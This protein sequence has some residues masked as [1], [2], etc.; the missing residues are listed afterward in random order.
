MY[1]PKILRFLFKYQ[2][3]LFFTF[4]YKDCPPFDLDKLLEDVQNGLYPITAYHLLYPTYS[5]LNLLTKPSISDRVLTSSS[6]LSSFPSSNLANNDH[7]SFLSIQ[8]TT[9]PLVFYPIH[10]NDFNGTSSIT[11]GTR[12]RNGMPNYERSTSTIHDS[13]YHTNDSTSTIINTNSSLPVT[14]QEEK[15]NRRILDIQSKIRSKETG[16]FLV[17]SNL[18]Q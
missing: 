3:N 15:E 17:K 16:S 1:S 4:S 13:E 10:T 7:D 6:S 2:S 12:A 8:S 5:T 14:N 11:N 9:D 18:F